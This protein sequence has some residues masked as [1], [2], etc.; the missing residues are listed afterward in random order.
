MKQL[1]LSKERALRSVA[2]IGRVN[3]KTKTIGILEDTLVGLR[4]WRKI[5]YLVKIGW[6]FNWIKPD[7]SK[8][9]K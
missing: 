6:T 2:R 9:E 1:P 5:D 8:K 3:E 7:K 4:V